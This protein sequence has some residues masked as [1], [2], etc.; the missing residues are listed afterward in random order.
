LIR[1]GT[2]VVTRAYHCILKSRS[3]YIGKWYC[4]SMSGVP[5]ERSAF[6]RR[7]LN[8]ITSRR[9]IQGHCETI[10]HDF[11]RVRACRPRHMFWASESW[12]LTEANGGFRGH[13][14]SSR[15]AT[16][17]R[18]NPFRRDLMLSIS[19]SHAI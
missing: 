13:V 8:R 15:S 3:R 11:S 18:G 12:R 4:R 1:V 6:N 14:T 19:S 2:A 9:R 5:L 16:S 7:G 17:L 10:P